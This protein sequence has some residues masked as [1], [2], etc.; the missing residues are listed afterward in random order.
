MET[1]RMTRDD[2]KQM[3][4]DHYKAQGKVVTHIFAHTNGYVVDLEGDKQHE[5]VEPERKHS[6]SK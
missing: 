6:D 1:I 5:P 4:Y 2:V 3:I